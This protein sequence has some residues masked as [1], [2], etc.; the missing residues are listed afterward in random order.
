MTI[1]HAV[2]DFQVS[3]CS[4]DFVKFMV[5]AKFRQQELAL[6]GLRI[7]FVPGR[8]SG[9]RDDAKPIS[10]AEKAWRRDHILVPACKLVGAEAVC[11]PRDL[12]G[13]ML[14]KEPAV[15]PHGWQPVHPL[16]QYNYSAFKAAHE[17]SQPFRFTPDPRAL[18]L[19]ASWLFSSK[20]DPHRLITIT[21]R[22]T[23]YAERNNTVRAWLAFADWLRAHGWSVVEI[24]DTEHAGMWHDPLGSIA[25]VDVLVRHALYSLAQQNMGV[26]N[27]PF[28]LCQYSADTPYLVTVFQRD[29]HHT[30]A[31]YYTKQGTPPGSQH[32]WPGP[33]RQLVWCDD[34]FDNLVS[35]FQRDL[36]AGNEGDGRGPQRAT[37]IEDES[38]GQERHQEGRQ[39]GHETRPLA[40][41][42][43][44]HGAVR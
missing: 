29:T 13:K 22:G 19:A 16:Q 11:L 34:N 33:H 23:Y 26:D 5:W 24:P 9:W 38:N 4:Y 12:V 31:D 35:V 7:Y 27:G 2:Y 6:P 28:A 8:D 14:A 40:V 39:E 15:F 36:A 44:E 30:R 10:N 3:P 43:G 20:R 42:P 21:Y 1:L 25:A 17:K 37:A 18:S 32:I 41:S